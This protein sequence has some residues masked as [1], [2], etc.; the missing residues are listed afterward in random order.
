MDCLG[1]AGLCVERNGSRRR[2]GTA[3]CIIMWV[4]EAEDG[5]GASR[6]EP[7]PSNSP[8]RKRSR[9]KRVGTIDKSAG[10]VLTPSPL[11]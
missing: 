10:A 1:L 3:L 2:P 5:L 6:S 4:A 11:S 7:E 8:A 9:A